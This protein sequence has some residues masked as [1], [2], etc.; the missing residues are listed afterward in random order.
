MCFVFVPAALDVITV[1]IP[2]QGP[3]DMS[4][5]F[6]EAR[7]VH[8]KLS[9]TVIPGASCIIIIFGMLYCRLPWFCGAVAGTS[10]S[11]LCANCIFYSA[12]MVLVVKT[13]EGQVLGAIISR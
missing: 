1:R 4:L 13:E 6:M 8:T 11:R 2:P 9:L 5:R 7:C 3:V 10:L 12:P